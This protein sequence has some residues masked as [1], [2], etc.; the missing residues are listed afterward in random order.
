[1][2][3]SEWGQLQKPARSR[4]GVEPVFGKKLI[5]IIVAL[6]PIFPTVTNWQFSNNLHMVGIV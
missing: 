1:L 6:C 2:F 5:W 3:L 4:A